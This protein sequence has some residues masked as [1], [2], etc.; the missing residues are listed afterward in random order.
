MSAAVPLRGLERKLTR[1]VDKKV[2]ASADDAGLSRGEELERRAS[3]PASWL[4]AHGVDA[5]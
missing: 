1:A 4:T 3:S 5:C 2:S